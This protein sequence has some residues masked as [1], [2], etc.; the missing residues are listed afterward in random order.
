MKEEN[1]SYS[2]FWTALISNVRPVIS[3]WLK[4][5]F[6]SVNLFCLMACLTTS[7]LFRFTAWRRS[8]VNRKDADFQIL[9]KFRKSSSLLMTRDQS[10]MQHNHAQDNMLKIMYSKLQ[11]SWILHQVTYLASKRASSKA[12]QVLE[13]KV[14]DLPSEIKA[15]SF[16]Q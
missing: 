9:L 2:P 1:Y 5:S 12:V 15:T 3:G 16:S 7:A 13:N 10:R 8:A 4:S 6:C 11:Y 14:T